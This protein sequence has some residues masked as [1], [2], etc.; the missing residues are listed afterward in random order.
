MRK[1]KLGEMKADVFP[2]SSGGE[3]HRCFVG[4]DQRTAEKR[5]DDDLDAMD[6]VSAPVPGPEANRLTDFVSLV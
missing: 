3:R 6:G 4:P 1:G 5:Q 2:I